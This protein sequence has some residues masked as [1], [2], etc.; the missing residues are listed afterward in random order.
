MS[1]GFAMSIECIA[2]IFGPVKH[3]IMSRIFLYSMYSRNTGS[4]AMSWILLTDFLSFTSYITTILFRGT[5][6]ATISSNLKN[7]EHRI[8]SDFH[9]F[10][11]KRIFWSLKKSRCTLLLEFAWPISKEIHICNL[12]RMHFKDIPYE[13]P[14]ICDTVTGCGICT[15]ANNS[16]QIY[17]NIGRASVILLDYRA[18]HHA[19]PASLFWLMSS[20]YNHEHFRI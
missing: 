20:Q 17:R 16:R 19:T 1:G 7:K 2:R 10:F 12:L 14:D 15:C 9:N 5:L 18:I 8:Y 13:C 11:S 3:S 4:N 6:P